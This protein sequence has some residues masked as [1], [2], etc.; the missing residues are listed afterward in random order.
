M[1]PSTAI[2]LEIA[3]AR[4]RLYDRTRGT[5]RQRR[6][7]RTQRIQ[8]LKRA[9]RRGLREIESEAKRWT[10]VLM[11]AMLCPMP[12]AAR[13]ERMREQL[14][15]RPMMRGSVAWVRE[16]LKCIA[17]VGEVEIEM[18]EP[19]VVS[20][21]VWA[22]PDAAGVLTDAVS[23]AL[24]HELPVGTVVRAVEYMRDDVVLLR[25]AVPWPGVGGGE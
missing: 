15:A 5:A 17:G 25:A 21:R 16:S 2:L 10:D 22:E 8:H 9:T 12:D 3:D 18:P 1:Y 4:W 19:G 6:R 7:V 14:H 20:V 11:S 24:Y 23:H 13:A